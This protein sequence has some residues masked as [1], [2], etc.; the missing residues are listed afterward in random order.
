MKIELVFE[1]LNHSRPGPDH[2][3][4]FLLLADGSIHKTGPGSA[5]NTTPIS[6]I[7]RC[8]DPESG[9]IKDTIPVYPVAWAPVPI[10]GRGT[11]Q[12]MLVESRK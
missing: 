2:E 7:V 12:T 4:V 1:P 8:V 6:V 11:I 9:I 5:S 3:E 10:I